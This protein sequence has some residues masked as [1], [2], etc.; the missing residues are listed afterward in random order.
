MGTNGLAG[1]DDYSTCG[2]SLSNSSLKFRLQFLF[3]DD[4]EAVWGVFV[5]LSR[6]SSGAYDYPVSNAE[7]FPVVGLDPLQRRH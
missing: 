4:Y 1:L 2:R 7:R 6:A 5:V 3:D